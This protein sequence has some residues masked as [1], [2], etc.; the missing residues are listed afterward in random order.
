MPLQMSGMSREACLSP[1]GKDQRGREIL[2]MKT[3]VGVYE[4]YHHNNWWA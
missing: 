2:K 3:G 4:V 1:E